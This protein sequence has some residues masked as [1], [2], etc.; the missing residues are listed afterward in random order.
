MLSC[1]SKD[2]AGNEVQAL[3][4]IGPQGSPAV[5][6]TGLSFCVKC[7]FVARLTR[8]AGL[9]AL[10]YTCQ[11]PDVPSLAK[12]GVFSLPCSVSLSP[13]CIVGRGSLRI[14]KAALQRSPPKPI[15]RSEEHTS[16]LQ[17]LMLILHAF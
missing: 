9:P 11:L 7:G 2:G 8:C 5:K 10:F 13:K 4:V 3:Y 16:V 6:T 1:R 17:S 15:S 12:I 14:E